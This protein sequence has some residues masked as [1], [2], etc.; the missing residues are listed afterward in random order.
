M[1]VTLQN[2]V[3]VRLRV[4]SALPGER[5]IPGPPA[6]IKGTLPSIDDLPPTGDP[7]D[8]Y[9][10]DS[11]GWAWDGMQW[12]DAGRFQ[13]E[14]GPIGPQ[15]IEGP[16]GPQGDVG[17][18]GP[19]GATGETGPQGDSFHIDATG[20]LSDKSL[21]DNEYEGFAF[22][23]TDTSNL[24]IRQG[25]PGGWSAAIPFGMGPQGPKGDQGPE[26][27]EGPAG[28]GVP[29]GGTSGQ[30]L[31]KQSGTDYDTVWTTLTKSSVG[32]ANVDNT[33]DANKPVSTAQQTA[34]NLKAN[35]ASPTFTGTPAAPTAAAGTSTTQLASTE[36]VTLA[37]ARKYKNA[38]A[39][40][41]T[42]GNFTVP[43]N[44]FELIVEVWGGGGGGG[45]NGTAS[46]CAGGGYATA[47]I[48]VTP[49]QV[50]ACTIGVGGAAGSGG[51]AGSAGG[52]TTFGAVVGHGGGGGAVN[53]LGAGGAGGTT[54]G[55]TVGLTGTRGGYGGDTSAV[56]SPTQ[57]G[58]WGG[59]PFQG[60]SIT[61][62]PYGGEAGL[63]PGGGGAGCGGRWPRS[64]W[65][66]RLGP[67]YCL[68]LRWRNVR[69]NY[70]G[71]R[72]RKRYNFRRRFRCI[73][74]RNPV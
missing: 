13:G 62:T 22:L 23:A 70:Q 31:L 20:N 55:G 40:I 25:G 69:S 33:S 21:Y 51:G 24:Y 26:G 61:G 46:Q 59:A 52:T 14:E 7:G 72:C 27:P 49:G 4:I 11:E 67:D 64:G 5:G 42:S 32:L 60:T 43:A 18:E 65:C 63:R 53:P 57:S 71:W 15:G 6:T 1:S 47:S 19:Q 39:V 73:N 38:V 17:P 37:I 12:V 36:F 74:R 66:W 9:T 50:I 28:P 54:S 16:E 2:G 45:G 8:I 44:V 3:H 34:L 48:S 29:V 56:G 35:I 58:G 41:T 68:L 30:A 10:I